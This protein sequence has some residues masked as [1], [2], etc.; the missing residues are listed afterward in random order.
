MLVDDVTKSLFYLPINNL[1]ASFSTDDKQRLTSTYTAAIQQKIVSAY[2]HLFTFIQQD[3]LPRCR[4]TVGLFAL[5]GGKEEY[6]F[7][8]KSWTTTDLTPDQ[9]H[10]IGLKEVARVRRQMEA[11]QQQ[12][13]FK[14]DL[15]AF[16][17]YL[18]TDAKFMPY[19]TE[20]DV[21]TGY[22]KIHETMKPYLSKLLNVLPK[23]AFE[24][25]PIESESDGCIGD[26]RGAVA[27]PKTLRG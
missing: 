2:T 22:R 12:V 20:E 25:R 6:A 5:P 11:I 16:F 14:G 18:V 13:G 23:A 9:I 21:V 26:E 15:N 7:L 24:V 4:P 10:E 8:V 3:Y 1:P 19:Q 17:Q 27:F